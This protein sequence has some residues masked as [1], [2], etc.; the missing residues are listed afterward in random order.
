MIIKTDLALILREKEI[1]KML[2]NIKNIS[3]S[4][5]I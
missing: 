3:L 2:V 5:I 4:K 1:N